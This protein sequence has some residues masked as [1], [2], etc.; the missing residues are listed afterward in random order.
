[1][2]FGRPKR[3]MDA[4]FIL[5]MNWHCVGSIGWNFGTPKI[6]QMPVAACDYLYPSC[7]YL[8]IANSQ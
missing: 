6:T 4:F 2:D 1:M 5:L 8:P 7:S 3:M